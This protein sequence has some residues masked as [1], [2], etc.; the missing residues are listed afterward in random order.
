MKKILLALVLV[1]PAAFAQFKEPF[2]VK[3][4]CLY[5]ATKGS[6]TVVN[7]LKNVITC[8]VSTYGYTRRG[9]RV[10]NDKVVVIEPNRWYVSSIEAASD[11]KFNEVKAEAFCR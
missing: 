11:D 10:A 5:T 9:A 1:S 4:G 2:E 6:C 7:K 3:A 8:E